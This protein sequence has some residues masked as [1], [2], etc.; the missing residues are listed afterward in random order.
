M[1]GLSLHAVC[2]PTYLPTS[3]T[4][5]IVLSLETTCDVILLPYS[6]YITYPFQTLTIYLSSHALVRYEEPLRDSLFFFFFCL[7]FVGNGKEW[8]RF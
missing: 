7:L 6:F 8:S 2:F 3:P 4:D 5:S 1:K